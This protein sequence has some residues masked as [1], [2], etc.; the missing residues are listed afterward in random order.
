MANNPAAAEAM[1]GW[2]LRCRRLTIQA[3]RVCNRAEG[4]VYYTGIGTQGSL[5]LLEAA[6]LADFCPGC[7]KKFAMMPT[8]RRSWVVGAS[9]LEC[10]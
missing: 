7:A 6:G 3:F 4:R 5:R 10:C 8:P 2:P 1:T 9:T